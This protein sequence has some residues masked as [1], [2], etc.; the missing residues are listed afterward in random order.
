[1]P[2]APPP[3][4]RVH[5]EPVQMTPPAVEAGDHRAHQFAVELGE[6]QRLGVPGDEPLHA[7]PVVA[8]AR[9]LG[10]LLPEVQHGVEVVGRRGPYP[11]V[12]HAVI[13][14]RPPRPDGKFQD[15]DGYRPRSRAITGANASM[16]AS[17]TVR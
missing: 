1:R 3:A 16:E 13:P 2:Y 6:D 5:R 8:D 15:P 4:L 12:G 17:S 10:G 11:Q 7:V 9:P 14:S